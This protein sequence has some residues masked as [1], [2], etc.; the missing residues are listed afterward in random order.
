MAPVADL[1]K[2]FERLGIGDDARIVLYGD[3]SGLSAA[4]AY[5]TL[6]SAFRLMLR[7][8]EIAVELASI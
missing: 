8:Q 3:N 6:V 1:Q 4:R 2:L 7:T 5:F